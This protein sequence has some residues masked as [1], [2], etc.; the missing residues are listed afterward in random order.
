METEMKIEKKVVTDTE[1]IS[2]DLN[3]EQLVFFEMGRLEII[4]S[5][6]LTFETVDITDSM[7]VLPEKLSSCMLSVV[8]KEG[9]DDITVKISI[10][11]L[12]AKDGAALGIYSGGYG[13]IAGGDGADGGNGADGCDGKDA[14]QIAQSEAD[15]SKRNIT[16]TG[17]KGGD[18][19]DGGNGGDGGD[20]GCAPYLTITCTSDVK[21]KITVVGD[22]SY[23]GKGGKGGRG[24]MGGKGGKGGLDSDGKKRAASGSDGKNGKDGENGKDA[25]NTDVIWI[26]S[27]INNEA[28]ET[29]G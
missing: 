4:D 2:S 20:G 10:N 7:L 24:G 11:N 22:C 3:V 5:C 27:D 13:G 6:K 9:N 21:S 1:L 25:V 18:G 28:G 14:G 19:G 26:I 15:T 29:D 16:A 23:G 12:K 8:P 17:G